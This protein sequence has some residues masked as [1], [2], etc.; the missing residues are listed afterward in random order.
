[1]AE[2]TMALQ[3]FVHKENSPGDIEEGDLVVLPKGIGGTKIQHPIH[4]IVKEV[5]SKPFQPPG[6]PDRHNLVLLTMDA[7]GR[8]FLMYSNRN[9]AELVLKGKR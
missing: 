2:L 8:P 7:L 3:V 5:L 1:M 4:A 6:S 9:H